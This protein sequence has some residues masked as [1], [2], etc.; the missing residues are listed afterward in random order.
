MSRTYLFYDLETSGLNPCFDQILQFAAIRTTLNLE[1][2]ERYQLT[3]KLNPDVLPSPYA[4]ITHRIPVSEWLK[5]ETE[6]EAIQKI[7]SW[8]NTPGTLSLGY[9][10][11]GFDDEFLRFSFFRNLL[12]PYTHQYA[13]QCGRLDI[14]PITVLYFLYQK[15]ALA[16][17]EQSGRV[18]LKLED[19]NA[20]NHFHQGRAHDA[21]VDVEVT[22]KLAQRLFQHSKMWD[23]AVGY[24]DKQ[25]DQY[26]MAKLPETLHHCHE[27][28]AVSPELRAYAQYQAQV[29]CLGTHAYYKNQTLWLRLDQSELLSTT[30]ES[31]PQKTW[32]LKKRFGEPCFLLP[33]KERF[34]GAIA[35]EIIEIV[36]ENRQFLMNNPS[37]FQQIRDYYQ[38]FQYPEIEDIDVDAALY[39]TGFLGEDEKR[40]CAQFHQASV[41]EKAS[42]ISTAPSDVLKTQAI[43]ILG[44]YFLNDVPSE[45]QENFSLYLKKIRTAPHATDFRGNMRLTPASALIEVK[46][47]RASQSLD[48]EQIGLLEG[49]EQY[50]HTLI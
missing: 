10:T 16:W 13:H 32:V 40:W 49:Y 8:M 46:Q 22:L 5:G 28:L 7:H 37:L 18:S 12:T 33:L 2:I 6:F 11:L 34:M 44:R 27:A 50:V 15:E 41:K 3:I 19:L 9:N 31:I 29:V 35:P 25:V 42:M 38:H 4:L 45:H 24:F 43:R 26:R 17:P 39:Q 14:F 23:Y 36:K 30:A 20:V 48:E 1:E 47:L 21:M